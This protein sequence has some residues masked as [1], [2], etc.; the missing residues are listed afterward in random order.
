MGWQIIPH[1]KY[2]S[3]VISAAACGTVCMAN[4]AHLDCCLRQVVR[5]AEGSGDVETEGIVV[6]NH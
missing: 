2:V 6:L 3:S 1:G 4:H 5:V